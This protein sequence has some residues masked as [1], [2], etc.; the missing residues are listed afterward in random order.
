MNGLSQVY[1][2]NLKEVPENGWGLF[3]LHQA[4]LKQNKIN[5]AENVMKRFNQAWRYSDIKLSS[6]RII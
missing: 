2:E 4:L 6:S 1:E 5:E 3:G